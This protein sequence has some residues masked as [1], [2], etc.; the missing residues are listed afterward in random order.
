MPSKTTSKRELVEPHIG[1]KRYVRRK[2]DGTFGRTSTLADH[3]PLTNGPR[4]RERFQKVRA[5]VAIRSDSSL[6]T[7][8][9]WQVGR[10]CS[11]YRELC[12][13][14]V[15]DCAGGDRNTKATYIC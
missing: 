12:Q 6:D 4:L 5:I 1:Y 14:T 8:G 11:K 15:R 10:T 13:K 3:F 7:V 2:A 9:R